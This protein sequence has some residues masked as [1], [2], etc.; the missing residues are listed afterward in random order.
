MCLCVV[1]ML[2][3]HICTSG[4]HVGIG[5]EVQGRW[6]IILFFE[7]RRKLFFNT[8]SLNSF[9]LRSLK[10]N[11]ELTDVTSLTST[12]ALGISCVQFPKPNYTGPPGPLRTYVC[13]GDH[14]RSSG[15][16]CKPFSHWAIFLAHLLSLSVYFKSY[17][18]CINVLLTCMSVHYVYAWYPWRSEE[19]VRSPENGA[20]DW[21]KQPFG[22]WESS[23]VPCRGSKHY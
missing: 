13:T 18:L 22:C 20:V 12:F 4:T 14:S 21:F 23:Q 3:I 17:F 5:V 7:T 1:F 19:D 6:W 11:S 15:S 8:L 10:S 9:L 16:H 2:C